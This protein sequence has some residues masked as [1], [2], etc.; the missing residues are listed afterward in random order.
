MLPRSLII[1]ML[2]V[3]IV[4]HTTQG[5][6]QGFALRL[7]VGRQHPFSCHCQNTIR[8]LPCRSAVTLQKAAVN[9]STYPYT[10][11]FTLKFLVCTSTFLIVNSVAPYRILSVCRLVHIASSICAKGGHPQPSPRSSSSRVDIQ[12]LATLWALCN[13]TE[14]HPWLSYRLK[15][16]MNYISL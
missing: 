1:G 15:K 12:R 16:S 6:I 10:D 13:Q 4:Q 14:T 8:F 5:Q 11:S 7:W 3:T 9:Q 2:T